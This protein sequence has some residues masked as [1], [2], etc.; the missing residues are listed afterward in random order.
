M[1]I[2]IGTIW[3]Q[4]QETLTDLANRLP[5]LL[6]A[7][8]TLVIF[9]FLAGRISLWAK[10]FIDKRSSS[11]NAATV[12]GLITRWSIIALGVL[13][14]LSIALPS[15]GAADL[16][17]A[18]GLGSVAIGFAFRDI[19][20]NFLAGLIILVTDAFKIGDQIVVESEDLEGTVTDIQTR[21][22]TILTYDD[23][24][25]IIPN[26]TLFTNAVTINTATE[27]RR[28]EQLVGISYD[29]DID[30]ATSLIKEAL[31]QID[32]VLSEPAPDI[33][34]DD[35]APSSVN[36]RVRWWTDARRSNLVATKSAV[37]RRIK[38]LLDEHGIDIPY[39]ARTLYIDSN[40]H[41]QQLPLPNTI[42]N[43]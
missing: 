5:A 1:E 26:A 19:F 23:R 17:Q 30:T 43:N 14:A 25:I 32:G 8:L 13:V 4:I 10:S 29:S 2:D 36:L 20:Q 21:A 9:Y 31:Y 22:T 18:L 7:L 34:V 41:E 11:K 3:T 39:P 37:V 15:F 42:S 24:Q 16:I 6:L 28:S 40:G 33:L 35:L 27:K 38:Y 12:T